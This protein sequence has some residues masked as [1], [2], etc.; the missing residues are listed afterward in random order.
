MVDT[1]VLVIGGTGHFGAS[2]ADAIAK[3]DGV[4]VQTAARSG[5]DVSID[6]TVPGTFSGLRGHDIIV[7]AADSITAPPDD[8]MR[9]ALAEGLTWVEMSADP[10]LYARVRDF[11]APLASG[12]V[13]LGAGLFPGLSTALAR[14]AANDCA[15]ARSVELGIRVSPLSGAGQASCALMTHTLTQRCIRYR[16]GLRQVDGVVGSGREMPFGEESQ[17]AVEMALPDADLIARSTRAAD[18]TTRVAF[19][20]RPL[21]GAFR[22]LAAMSTLLGSLRVPL[23]AVARRAL[24]SLRAVL[25]RKVVT[26]VDLTAVA[27]DIEGD[28]CVRRVTVPDGRLATAASVAVLVAHLR[29]RTIATGLSTAGA[30][31]RLDAFVHGMRELGIAVEDYAPRPTRDSI[32]P[33]PPAN[34]SSLIAAAS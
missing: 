14:A 17:T 24:I 2:V 6:L 29:G 15:A 27:V 8:A 1:R 30:L 20:P 5:A 34:D 22:M 9:Y 31:V 26:R 18:V 4:L 10:A 13:V 21:L 32:Q 12:S 7:N 16:E 25:L 33:G 19:V 3:L 11:D 28:T 23:L